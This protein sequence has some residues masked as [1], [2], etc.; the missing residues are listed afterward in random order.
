MVYYHVDTTQRK[1]QS[2]GF[3]GTSAILDEPVPAHA[4]YYDT[5]T[6]SIRLVDT[7]SALRRL[8]HQRARHG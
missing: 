1:L 3:T 2:L 4:H 5:A 6:P 8:R 7:G